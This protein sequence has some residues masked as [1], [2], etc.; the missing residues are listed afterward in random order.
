[1]DA[2]RQRLKAQNE[3]IANLI[4]GY[5]PEIYTKW[6]IHFGAYTN[7]R[8][9]QIFQLSLDLGNVKVSELITEYKVGIEKVT[10]DELE[11]VLATEKE[12][13]TVGT[14]QLVA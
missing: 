13:Y 1:M 8:L 11:Q 9:D 4:S 7:L 6:A 12:G 3:K 2:T 5:A 14:I 10:I